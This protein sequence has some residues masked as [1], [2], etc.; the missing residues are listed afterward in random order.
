MLRAG[1]EDWL[2]TI[3]RGAVVDV[4]RGPLVMPSWQTR[5][6]APTAE[7][8]AFLEPVPRPGH[9][10][11]IALLRRGAIAFEGDLHPLMANLHYAKLLLASLRTPEAAA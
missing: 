7:W 1:G 6:A 10:D 3:R 2:A 8:Q 4:A 11:I 9:H 5:I